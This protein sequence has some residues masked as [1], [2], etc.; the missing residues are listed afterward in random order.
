MGARRRYWRPCDHPA[1]A[2]LHVARHVHVAPAIVD[3]LRPLPR[4]VKRNRDCGECRILRKSQLAPH[5][6]DSNGRV[7]SSGALSRSSTRK[8]LSG[9]AFAVPMEVAGWLSNPDL[10]RKLQTLL[11]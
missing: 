2:Q 6:R 3:D 11:Q 10:I 5:W 1:H 4:L 9:A 7:E 8:P